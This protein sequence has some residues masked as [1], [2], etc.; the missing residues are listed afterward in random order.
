VLRTAGEIQ[1]RATLERGIPA[2]AGHQTGRNDVTQIKNRPPRLNQIYATYPTPLYFVTFNTEQRSPILANQPV[3]A[4]FVSAAETA[5]SKGATVGRYVIMP[6]HVHLFI[7]IGTNAR[8]G[9]SVTCLKR[10]ITKCVHESTPGLHVW[11]EGFFDHLIRNAE[12]YAEK[13]EYVYQNPVRAGLVN[14][15]KEWPYQG[16]FRIIDRAGK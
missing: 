16:E 11:Q 12:S 13:W 14:D 7:R 5:Y 9:L 10:S 6:D 8:L 15:P 3:H 1:S 2:K 4:A